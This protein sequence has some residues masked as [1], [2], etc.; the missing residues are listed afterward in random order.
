MWCI[1][2]YL[3]A[4]WLC[5]LAASFYGF[6]LF[7]YD[8]Y[9]GLIKKKINYYLKYDQPLIFF[10]KNDNIDIIDMAGVFYVYIKKYK[11]YGIIMLVFSFIII[12]QIFFIFIFL[13]LFNLFR[14][15]LTITINIDNNLT[16][17]MDYFQYS[18]K[19]G[20]SSDNF[21]SINHLIKINIK[22]IWFLSKFFSNFIM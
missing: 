20:P 2:L 10:Y 22:N 6:L 11:L 18:E 8:I 4:L 21:F 14:F 1:K 12:N 19:D 9:N 5:F 15:I 13:F 16:I 7:F 17:S 3:S